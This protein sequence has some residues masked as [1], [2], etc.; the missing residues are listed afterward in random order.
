VNDNIQVVDK[1]VAVDYKGI[2]VPY[3]DI[4]MMSSQHEAM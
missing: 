4:V 1:D 3:K 2:C